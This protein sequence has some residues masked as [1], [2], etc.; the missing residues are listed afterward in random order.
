MRADLHSHTT[1]SDGLLTVDELLDRAIKNKVDVLAITDHDCV[2]GSEL[3]YVTKKDI[4][5][6]YGVELST[7]RNNESVHILGYFKQPL[8]EGS[9]YENMKKQ[10][11]NRIKRA[12]KILELL[13]E[14]FRIELNPDF[15]YQLNSITRGTIANEIIKQG[16]NYTKKHIFEYILGDGCKAYIPST[17]M[18]TE[19]GIKL[20][21]ESGGIAVVAHP[22][23]YKKNNVYDIIK[24]GI[25]G[26]EG[27]YPSKYNDE[28]M[29]RR[30]TKNN[31]LLFTAG[32]DFH[33]PNDLG[34]GEV[35][36]C[37]IDGKDLEKFLEVLYD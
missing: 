35:G 24:L 30:F 10:R 1:F 5:I 29:Y 18:T 26:I 8:I 16:Y 3:A 31:N 4:K 32:S 11:E 7:D 9:L 14:H 28:S 21:H 6:I 34:H 23:L 25:D 37:T 12:F 2:D 22:C 15:I 36:Q 17:K 20:I 33:Y 19:Y 27:R 13:K